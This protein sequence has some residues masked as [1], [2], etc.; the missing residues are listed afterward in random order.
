M[1]VYKKIQELSEIIKVHNHAYYVLDVPTISDYDF[2]L[3]LKELGVLEQENP[4][5]ID[6]NSPTQRVGDIVKSFETEPHELRMYSLDNSY[7]QEDLRD[8]EI[9]IKKVLED[10]PLEY[11]CELKYDGASI[12]LTYEKGILQKALT[13]GDGFQGDNVTTNIRTIKS[14][15]LKL[16]GNYP[17]HFEIRGEVVM[18]FEGFHKMNEQRLANGEEPFMNPRNTASGSLKIQNPQLAAKR[19]LDCLLYHIAGEHKGIQSQYEFLEKARSWGFKVPNTSKKCNNLAAV[20]EFIDYWD[21]ARHELPYETD[22]VVIK[23]DNL[24][25]QA[26]LGYTSKSPRWAMAYKFKAEKVSTVFKSIDYQVGRTG[27][28]TPVANLS[29]VL[30]AGTIVKRASL[31][32]ADQIEKLDL[33]IGDTVFVEKGGEIIPKI[34]GIDKTKRLLNAPPIVYINSC[35]QCGSSLS[36]IDGEAKHFCLNER[37]C[38]PQIIGKISHFISRKALDI[39]GLGE[40]TVSLLYA[41]GLL[42]NYADLYSLDPAAV[43]K[44]DRMAE[45]SVENILI[46][47]EASKQIP[48]EKVLFGLG[49]RFVGETVAK[50]LAKAFVSIDG[51]M[52]ASYEALISVDEIGDRI[53]KSVLEFFKDPY[54]RGL[55]L[56]L[57]KYGLKLEM[58][59]SDISVQSSKLEGFIFVLSGVYDKYS[60]PQLKQLIEEHGGKVVGSLSL[61]TSFLLAGDQMG[62]SKKDKAAA[63]NIPLLSEV[64]FIEMIS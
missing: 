19:P 26:Q 60:R 18:P 61:K 17:T 56:R 29:P 50:K 37:A 4:L 23:I 51:L 63:L 39:D 34:V 21:T 13:R 33:R 15:P 16:K 58:L 49:I 55:V 25:H 28:L 6:L 11:T 36:R 47:I 57:A 5:F 35:P 52:A 38:P 41:N 44:L 53:A 48:Y 40:E 59:P 24:Q 14:I 54:Q 43:L 8:W 10:I 31:H 12:S 64:S 45:K 46:G 62:P 7:D 3:L 32:N 20:Y 1:D 27:A 22:G 9:R 2:D 30:L 42:S